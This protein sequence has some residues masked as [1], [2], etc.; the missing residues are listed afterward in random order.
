MGG[1]RK[2][3]NKSTEEKL[4]INESLKE[5]S[6]VP[7]WRALKPRQKR[8]LSAMAKCELGVVKAGRVSGVP[9]RQHYLWLKLP[10]YQAG[11][12]IV[13]KIIGNA[14]LHVM[15]SDAVNG[16]EV[17]I[18]HRGQVTGYRT[19][20]FPQ[21]R[22]KL[23]QGFDKRFADSA[24]FQFAGPTQLNIGYSSKPVEDEAVSL[25]VSPVSLPEPIK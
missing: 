5:L 9:W 21:E 19:D 6:Q 10:A 18:T 15:L 20:V 4:F 8:F 7:E 11:M 13:D 14:L 16:R 22:I 1:W 24:Q 2:E 25:P 23:L 17:P 12:D 3:A